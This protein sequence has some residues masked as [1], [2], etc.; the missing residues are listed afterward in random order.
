MKALDLPRHAQI[1]EIGCGTGGNLPMLSDFGTVCGIEISEVARDLAIKKTGG[2]FEIRA[3]TLPSAVPDFGRQFDLICLFD[4]L[5]HIDDDLGTLRAVACL[6]KPGG[7]LII[8][9][10][11]YQWMWSRHD[12]FLHHHR[13]YS[14]IRLIDVV[15]SAGLRLDRATYFNMWLFPA[16]ALVRSF[17]KLRGA[18]S[19]TGTNIPPA[20]INRIMRTIFASE[21]HLLERTGLPFGLSLLC[22]ASA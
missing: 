2:A 12:E 8:S 21:R 16:A 17:D 3:G 9:V 15:Q 14:K 18:Q 6:V 10:P 7:R 4:V 1:L 22:V 20:L 5:E 13:R 11:A 19:A